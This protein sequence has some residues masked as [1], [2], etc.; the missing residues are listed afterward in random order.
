M[1]PRA[2]HEDEFGPIAVPQDG[3]DVKLRGGF[4]G[5]QLVGQRIA[6][7]GGGPAGMSAALERARL[8]AEVTLF[9]RNSE[10]GGQFLLAQRIPG[11][12]EFN[13]TIRYFRTQLN[14][15]N[16]SVQLNTL[17]TNELLAG[18]DEVVVATGVRPRLLNIPGSDRPEVV[19]YVDVLKGDVEVGARVAIVGAGGIGFD[20]ADFLTEDADAKGFMASWGVD[21]E[22]EA[23]GGV[24]P[25]QRTAS[26][27][28]V[29]MYQRRPGKMGKGLGRTTGWIHRR[30]LKQ[31][32]VIQWS[33]VHYDFIDDEGFHVTLEDGT[34]HVQSV[35]HVVVCAGQL[36]FVPDGL[37]HPNMTVIGGA[38]DASGLDAQRAILEGMVRIQA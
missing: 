36:S 22:A 7:V 32:G 34:P 29:T 15:L 14:H 24:V 16:V 10:L 18:F 25:P 30:S 38:R 35:D 27:R 20:V 3:E 2:C 23:R 21:V 31:R 13:E 9:E 5:Q 26:R 4:G 28:N 17:A 37:T 1:N 6:V 19:S 33:G 8:G 12:F 11:K